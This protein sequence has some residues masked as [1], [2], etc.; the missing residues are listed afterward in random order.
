MNIDPNILNVMLGVVANGFTALIASSYHRITGLQKSKEQIEIQDSL[1]KQI[2][3]ALENVSDT[4]EWAGPPEIEELC[5]FITSP[6]VNAVVRQLYAVRLIPDQRKTASQIKEEFHR[7]F[8]YHFSLAYEES[9][10]RA[11]ALFQLLITAVEEM[12][13]LGSKHG[14]LSAQDARSTARFRILRDELLTLKKNLEL[15]TSQQLDIEAINRFVIRYHEQISDRHGRITPP[16]FDDARKLPIDSIYVSPNFEWVGPEVSIH[17][18]IIRSDSGD[19][20]LVNKAIDSA[21]ILFPIVSEKAHSTRYI[22]ND[23][24]ISF[25]RSFPPSLIQSQ[26]ELFYDMIPRRM[27]IDLDTLLSKV[28]RTVVLGN[29]GG[30]KSTLTNKICYDFTK[31]NS[32]KQERQDLYRITPIPVILREYGNEKKAHNHSI[33]QFIEATAKD[34]YQVAPPQGAFEYLLLNGRAFVIFDGLD[35]LLETGYRQEIRDDIESFCNLYP[36]VPVIITSREVGYEQ[37]PLDQEKFETYRLA[38]FDEGQV[39]EYVEKWFNTRS[40]Y[41]S[42]QKQQKSK[43]FLHESRIVSD[44]RSNPLMLGLMCNIYRGESYIPKNRPDVYRKCAEMLFERWD[45][46]REI[47]IT[48]HF[49]DDI[50]PAMAYLAYWIYEDTELQEGVT[51]QGLINKAAMYL[52][53]QRYDNRDRAERAAREFIEFCRGRA[54]VFTD[55]GTDREGEGLYQFTHRTFLEYFT[56]LY[57]VRTHETT[58]ELVETLMP[59]I[60]KREWDIVA[61]LAFQIKNRSSEGAKDKLLSYLLAP[62][63]NLDEV[64]AW[65]LLSFAARC[66]E[67]MEPS[68][69]ITRDITRAFIGRC[70]SLRSQIK[71]SK[72]NGNVITPNETIYNLLQEV[73]RALMAAGQHNRETIAE[74][75]KETIIEYVKTS[76]QLDAMAALEIAFHL[77]WPIETEMGKQENPQSLSKF[78][79]E[80]SRNIINETREQIAE[81]SVHN[82]GLSIDAYK[83]KL[84]DIRSI[85]SRFGFGKLFTQGGVIILKVQREPIALG[86]IRWI[87]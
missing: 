7:L 3:K 41:T 27:L 20:R 82:V 32:R 34:K 61:Q 76:Q 71:I 49:E 57:L 69:K 45:R 28:N 15:L 38:P 54:W 51:E 9:Q 22:I 81:L 59:R 39:Q 83:Q 6:E 23:N 66:L 16:N 4:I 42:A 50:R 64:E 70:I 75:L 65:S 17:D 19:Y 62:L 46:S 63:T 60:R 12:V 68:P 40:E 21:K 78:W 36:S 58:E 53:E 10:N 24:I 30:G 67:F 33:L 48:F 72:K 84:L 43:D 52:L 35:E 87:V 1:S 25:A 79:N 85:I 56:A 8:S 47:P 55:A 18:F 31:P 44:L 77:D 86:S 26:R 80:V 14:I 11:N 37:A 74:S 73:F 2:R 5:L 13:A 29:P